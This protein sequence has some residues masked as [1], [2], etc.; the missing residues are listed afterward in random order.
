MEVIALGKDLYKRINVCAK[1]G[2]IFSTT[3]DDV[4]SYLDQNVHY[5]FFECPSCYTLIP[6]EIKCFGVIRKD[7]M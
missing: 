1:C 5:K 6:V 7:E 3:R 4:T 2:C